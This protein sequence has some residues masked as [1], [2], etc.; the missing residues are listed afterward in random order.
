[1][2]ELVLVL[3]GAVVKTAIKL[4][5]GDNAFADS[6]SASLTD[7]LKGQVSSALDQ[8]RIRRQ[9]EN[10]EEIVARQI[11][12][13][14]ENEFRGLDEG[15]RNASIIAVGETLARAQLTDKVLFAGT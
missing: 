1:M 8:R 11:L 7:M 14:L 12:S 6:L 9:F 4:W 10:L 13:T 5:T 15:E 2:T 3:C